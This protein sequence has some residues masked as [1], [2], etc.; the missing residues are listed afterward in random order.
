MNV[1]LTD[2]EP[3]QVAPCAT[4]THSALNAVSRTLFA[5]CEDKLQRI[6]VNNADKQALHFQSIEY[7]EEMWDRAPLTDTMCDGKCA[8]ASPKAP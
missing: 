6:Y 7:N 3:V 1:H 5:L 4:F 2:T 8:E